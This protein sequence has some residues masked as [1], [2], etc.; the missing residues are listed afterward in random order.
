MDK[1]SCVMPT[2]NRR[3]FIGAAIDSWQ[4]QTYENRELIILDDGEDSIEDVIEKIDDKRIGYYRLDYRVTTGKKRNLVNA[5]A[6]GKW[7]CHFDD[8]DWSAPERIEY[9]M[10]RL[11]VMG[12]IITGFGRMLFWDCLKNRALFYKSGTKGY[13]CGTSLMYSKKLWEGHPF[14]NKQVASDNDFVYPIA[15]QISA[16]S[17]FRYMVARIHK[18]HTSK[19]SGIKE[20]VA[21]KSI[22]AAFWDNE[23]LRLQ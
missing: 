11:R 14:K 8:D 9:Q 7:I 6:S 21:N 10:D 3:Q 13:V 16:S 20:V 19:K 1:I 15:K 12:S 23:K 18:S 22:P 2:Q 5:I 17:E 4:K